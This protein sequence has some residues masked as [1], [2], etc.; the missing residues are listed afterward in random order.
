MASVKWLA[1][2]EALATPFRGFQQVQTYVFRRDP[3][4][5][6]IPVTTMRVRSLMVPPGVPDWYTRHRLVE[7]G[8]VELFGRAWS[9]NG[10]CPSLPFLFSLF[11][12]FLVTIPPLKRCTREFLSRSWKGSLSSRLAPREVNPFFCFFFPFLQYARPFRCVKSTPFLLF[13]LL[14]CIWAF[15]SSTHPFFPFS[16]ACCVGLSLSLSLSLRCLW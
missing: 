2:I 3:L 15:R 1:R 14:D 12:P 5:P 4:D 8:P 11:L 16:F 6:G 10:V 7:R 9:G 13:S